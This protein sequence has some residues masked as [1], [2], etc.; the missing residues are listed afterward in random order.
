MRFAMLAA[1]A[2]ALPS[3]AQAATIIQNAYS[4]ATD[5]L[6][7][8][9]P[10][11]GHLDSVKLDLRID[12][13][14]AFYRGLPELPGTPNDVQVD[15]TIDGFAQIDLPL[16][17]LGQSTN[18][19]PISGSG[20]KIVQPQSWLYISAQGAASFD[21]DPEAVTIDPAVSGTSFVWHTYALGLSNPAL[22]TVLTMQHPLNLYHHVACEGGGGGTPCTFA[23]YTL[24]YNYTPVTA[25]VPEP[26]TWAMMLA[27]FGAIGASMRR[28][29]GKGT[30]HNQ[31][32]SRTMRAIAF[33]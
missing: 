17:G 12:S 22:D 16:L 6:Y 21:I 8:F 10:T 15:W 5:W 19:I 24:T 29:K 27:G 18:F 32:T 33:T 14:R 20:S 25:L 3:S 28:R 7:K 2:L 1:A 13:R 31:P 30:A 4:Y 23:W 26:A 11:L 9:D